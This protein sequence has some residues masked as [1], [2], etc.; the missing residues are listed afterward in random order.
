MKFEFKRL[1]LFVFEKEKEKKETSP[2]H[3]SAQS[4]HRPISLP[5]AAAHLPASFF[6]FYVPLT[7]RRHLSAL[8]PPLAPIP[9]S[10]EADADRDTG[11]AHPPSLAPLSIFKSR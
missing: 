2:P 11:R 9:F 5:P 8:L 4:A 3:H 7:R 1:V 6:F 10:V